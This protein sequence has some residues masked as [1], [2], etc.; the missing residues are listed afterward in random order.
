MLDVI[1]KAKKFASLNA[2]ILIEGESGTGKEVFAQA[3]H[4]ASRPE[5]PFVAVN[6]AAIPQNLIESELFGYKGGSFTGAERQG[7]IGKIELAEGGTLFLDEIGDMPLTLQPVLLRA[8]EEK[9]IMRVGDSRYISVNFNLIAAT[10]KDL[11]KLVKAKLF[12][13]DLYYRLAVLKIA[14]PP[15]R[16]RGADIVRLAK[17]FIKKFGHYGYQE[18]FRLSDEVVTS[19][20]KYT[21][22]GNV[23]QLENT[24]F[25]SVNMSS[26]GLISCESLPD[27]IEV[28][29]VMEETGDGPSDFIEDQAG[30]DG[31]G[32]TMKDLEKLTIIQTL[33]DT[34][35]NVSKA[36]CILGV[37][38]STLYRKIKKYNINIIGSF[39]EIKS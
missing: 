39:S 36:S 34:N 19:L 3:I 25:Y 7:R 23:R 32:I 12:R 16:D 31:T 38:K 17:F 35:N 1:E 11:K 14:I 27:E 26:N 33:K 13:E 9:K 28:D 6:C 20:L 18:N 15:L 22:P 8:L 29:H 30:D 5:G 4:N 10:N 2:N 24:M 21:W 37:C